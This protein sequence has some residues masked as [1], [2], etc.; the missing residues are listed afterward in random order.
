MRGSFCGDSGTWQ[1]TAGSMA[2]SPVV[3]RRNYLALSQ[4]QQVAAFSHNYCPR[5]QEQVA[6][7][8]MSG[9]TI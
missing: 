6:W 8:L 2:L 5:E 1:A 4:K 9:L 3:L 7:G